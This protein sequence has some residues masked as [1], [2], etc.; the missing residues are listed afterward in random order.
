M[1]CSKA[2]LTIVKR[3]LC[4]VQLLFKW[5]GTKESASISWLD[6]WKE[7]FI[8][9]TLSGLQSLF[10]SVSG[11]VRPNA[12]DE[13]LSSKLRCCGCSFSVRRCWWKVAASRLPP[14][15]YTSVVCW[16]AVLVYLVKNKERISTHSSPPFLFLPYYKWGSI[17]RMEKSGEG[18]MDKSAVWPKFYPHSPLFT[19][20]VDMATYI[21]NCNNSTAR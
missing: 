5:M 2:L 9:F 16:T 13:N 4:G 12:G 15:P 17:H 7:S 1:P 18:E 11:M 20:K 10:L 8:V 6:T 14:A 3:F 19:P 21:C